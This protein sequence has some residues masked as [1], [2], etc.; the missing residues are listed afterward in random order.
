MRKS[1]YYEILGVYMSYPKKL[2]DDRL[3]RFNI[4]LPNLSRTARRFM[5]SKHSCFSWAQEQW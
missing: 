2:Y 3:F 5:W 4:I 1:D